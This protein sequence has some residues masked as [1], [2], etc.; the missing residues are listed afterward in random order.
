MIYKTFFKDTL[1]WGSIVWLVGYV[2][3]FAL[4]FIVPVSMVGWVVMPFGV[5]FTLWVLCKKV[6][7]DSMRKRLALAIVWTILAIALDYL[8]I[9][10][11]FHPAD[12]Y[13]KL[14][15][16]VYYTLTFVLPFIVGILKKSHEQNTSTI[17]RG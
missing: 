3:G 1:G 6:A 13:Y 12:G 11:A 7:T 9:V 4:V 5:A 2:L 14:D 17:S 8:F 16:Y 15:V 10:K